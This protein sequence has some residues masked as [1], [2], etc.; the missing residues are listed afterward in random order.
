FEMIMQKKQIYLL[1]ILKSERL[2]RKQ[3]L[4]NDIIEWILQHGGG[5]SSAEYANTQGK[6][7]VSC[8]SE[9]IWY[10]DMHGHKKFEERSYHIPELFLGFFGRANPESYKA[11]RKPFNA[12]ELNL[13]CQALTLHTTLPW[14]FKPLFTWLREPY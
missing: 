10:I 5:W 7:F 2:N 11:S 6:K 13:H 8:L 4:Y 1:P 14:I 12:I 9:A 3:T